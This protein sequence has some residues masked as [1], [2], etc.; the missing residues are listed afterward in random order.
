MVLVETERDQS[1]C[2]ESKSRTPPTQLANLQKVLLQRCREKLVF[3][4][5]A[6]E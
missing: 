1:N 4:V 2:I 3:Q 6:A 5:G